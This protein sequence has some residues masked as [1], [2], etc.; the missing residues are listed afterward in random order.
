MFLRRIGWFPFFSSR[1]NNFSNRQ[2][3]GIICVGNS[4]NP[5]P[6]DE[7][8][9]VLQDQN[10]MT[11]TSTTDISGSISNSV[12]TGNCVSTTGPNSNAV[13]SCINDAK[14][15]TLSTETFAVQEG[16]NDV[17]GDG[18]MKGCTQYLSILPGE[19]STNEQIAL[20][21]GTMHEF[22]KDDL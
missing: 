18:Q 7:S 2:Q 10:P 17:T 21:I 12:K 1:N 3:I 8:T 15:T 9:D 14:A 6:I 19:L 13:I 16:D 5:C 22:S 4:T 20:A 11:V